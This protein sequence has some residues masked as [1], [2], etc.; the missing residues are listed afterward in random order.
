MLPACCLPHWGREVPLKAVAENMRITEERGFQQ[1][2]NIVKI[3]FRESGY[4][5]AFLNVI[6]NGSSNT[7]AMIPRNCRKKY[8]SSSRPWS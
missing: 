6:R 4:Y 8:K 1:S 5:G 7:T 3:V 2:H